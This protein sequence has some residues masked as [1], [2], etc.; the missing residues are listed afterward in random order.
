LKLRLILESK[1]AA[2]EYGKISEFTISV[3]TCWYTL[4]ITLADAGLLQVLYPPALAAAIFSMQKSA[5]PFDLTPQ[6]FAF[7]LVVLFIMVYVIRFVG[8]HVLPHFR[9]LQEI[10]AAW[11][12][13]RNLNGKAHAVVDIELG[14]IMADV[15][16]DR[17]VVGEETNNS[18]S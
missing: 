16:A 17:I 13:N 5:V 15:S 8:R 14:E 10:S 7:A 6:A 18:R 2:D 3:S 4:E 12:K 11:L 1:A 9:V